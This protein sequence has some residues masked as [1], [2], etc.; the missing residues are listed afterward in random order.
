MRCLCICV[1]VH[2][3]VCLYVLSQCISL[4]VYFVTRIALFKLVFASVMIF[5]GDVLYSSMN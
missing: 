2:V 5:V 4:Y 1:C 3:S